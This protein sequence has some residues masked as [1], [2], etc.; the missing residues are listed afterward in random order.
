MTPSENI[1][2]VGEYPG[3]L[4]YKII[5][6]DE[7]SILADYLDQSVEAKVV[8]YDY[9]QQQLDRGQDI[10]DQGD[11]NSNV[12]AC[13]SCHE[14]EDNAFAGKLTFECSDVALV[15]AIV[16]A[17][18]SEDDEYDLDCE[19]YKLPDFHKFPLNEEDTASILSYI[20]SRL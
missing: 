9:T 10:F 1:E 5:Q 15:G 14:A 18:F 11:Q 17:E 3:G 8:A 2:L 16:N 4:A 13:V 20:R 12:P 6:G 7:H 19:G